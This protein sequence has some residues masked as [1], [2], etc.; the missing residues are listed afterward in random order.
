P[1]TVRRKHG[2]TTNSTHIDHEI[3]RPPWNK[4]RLIGPKP[5]LEL[6][7]IWATRIH[8]QLA[9]RTRDLALWANVS[10]LASARFRG[11]AEIAVT[12][13]ALFLCMAASV[14]FRWGH[15]AAT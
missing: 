12:Q 7:D 3:R 6:K 2:M 5:S 10:G 9:Q 14:A 8:L 4:D 11:L 15:E 13:N 1:H